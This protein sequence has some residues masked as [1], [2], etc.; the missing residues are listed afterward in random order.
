MM[1]EA[2][3]MLTSLYLP[4][5]MASVEPC[6]SQTTTSQSDGRGR[7]RSASKTSLKSLK[8]SMLEKKSFAII[9]GWTVPEP[10]GFLPTHASRC[11]NLNR[12]GQGMEFHADGQLIIL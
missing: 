2:P 8:D 3:T 9:S 5:F 10:M 1:A 11:P 6:M 7:Y 4:P 12:E